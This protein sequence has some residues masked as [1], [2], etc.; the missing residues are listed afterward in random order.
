[1]AFSPWL[2]IIEV[3]ESKTPTKRK[4]KHETQ[5]NLPA[6]SLERETQRQVSSHPNNSSVGG[7]YPGS[8]EG[9][10]RAS[11][12]TAQKISLSEGLY[13]GA[14]APNSLLAPKIGAQESLR[15]TINK[16][17]W[18][19]PYVALSLPPN[20]FAKSGRN[21]SERQRTPLIIVSTTRTFNFF[22]FQILVS[23]YTVLGDRKVSTGQK[24]AR[25]AGSDPGSSPGGSTTNTY[26]T[27]CCALLCT[28]PA[29]CKR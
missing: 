27:R 14:F 20:R 17:R 11:R 12:K 9:T 7:A 16:N 24:T 8:L 19:L 1:V 26:R 15:S 28:K 4:A 29:K 2:P 3:A 25:G 21:N 23:R 18:G 10:T 5:R 22:L 13:G 6:P